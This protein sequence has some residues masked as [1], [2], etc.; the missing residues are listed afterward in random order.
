MK[1]AQTNPLVKTLVACASVDR[2]RLA[3]NGVFYAVERGYW[4]ASDGRRLFATNLLPPPRVP[5]P[6]GLYKPGPLLGGDEVPWP[7]AGEWPMVAL[8]SDNPRQTWPDGKPLRLTRVP[9]E[10]PVYRWDVPE[11]VTLLEKANRQNA[12]LPAFALRAQPQVEAT[13]QRGEETRT[14]PVQL[15]SNLFRFAW[16]Q[17]DPVIVN[18]ASLAP[19]AG[20]SWYLHLRPGCDTVWLTAEPHARLWEQLSFILIT[21]CPCP[22]RRWRQFQRCE[23]KM[24]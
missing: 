9:D 20:T 23:E 12:D 4:L 18:L 22:G 14:D 13:A 1:R 15:S 17:H 3:L 8:D 16:E 10:T 2:T 21:T 24:G 5:S 7:E 6:N 19:W 11:W